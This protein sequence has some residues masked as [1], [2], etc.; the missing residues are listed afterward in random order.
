LSLS[1]FVSLSPSLF[2]SFSLC[3]FSSLIVYIFLYYIA[4]GFVGAL[5]EKRGEVVRSPLM[6]GEY[7]EAVVARALWGWGALGGG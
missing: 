6:V 5:S 2:V 3:L 7:G 4:L 1:I